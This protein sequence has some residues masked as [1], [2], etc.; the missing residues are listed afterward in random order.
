MNVL[1]LPDTPTARRML[2]ELEAEAG[3]QTLARRLEVREALDKVRAGTKEL[4]KAT[5]AV[6]K[7]REK[8]SKKNEE[9]RAAVEELY[10]AQQAAHSLTTSRAREM[11]RLEQELRET[12]P[13]EVAELR[14]WLNDEYERTR[15]TRPEHATKTEKTWE[16]TRQVATDSTLT[17]IERRLAY[18][19]EIRRTRLAEIALMADPK[20][21]RLAC[22][23]VRENLPQI[24]MEPIR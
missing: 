15:K 5:A 17:S 3:E 13:P 2:A 4:S 20:A 21:V 7:A 23:E 6:D 18:I 12:A 16:G 14:E 1:T 22:E 19:V 10:R 8:V 24:E 11:N 9:A